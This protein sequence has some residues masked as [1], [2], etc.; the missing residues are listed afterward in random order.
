MGGEKPPYSMNKGIQFLRTINFK[1]IWPGRG[2]IKIYR[3]WLR[4][5]PLYPLQLV[6]AGPVGPSTLC[7]HTTAE[8]LREMH[9]WISLPPVNVRESTSAVACPRPRFKSALE[10][11]IKFP[12][13]SAF[14]VQAPFS[15]LQH[16]KPQTS[17]QTKL[18]VW[19]KG[20]IM[21]RQEHCDKAN[22]SQTTCIRAQSEHLPAMEVLI[23]LKEKWAILGR[24]GIISTPVQE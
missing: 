14:L 19:C 7:I 3:K 11:G 6:T 24:L 10:L 8:Q 23:S 13:H 4:S 2:T 5:T 15:R 22:G 9:K 20:K 12:N 17:T 16:K 18:T 1:S 21:S